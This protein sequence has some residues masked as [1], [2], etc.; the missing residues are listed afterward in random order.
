[1]TW[2]LRLKCPDPT[3]SISQ[4][5]F[6]GTNTN[7]TFRGHILNQ[8]PFDTLNGPL[9]IGKLGKMLQRMRMD[10]WVTNQSFEADG[11]SQNMARVT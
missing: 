3:E 10:L 9:G 8:Q 5:G 11:N 2:L 7:I 6:G 1:M 4:K